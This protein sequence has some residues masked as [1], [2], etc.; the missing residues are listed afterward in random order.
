MEALASRGASQGVIELWGLDER[1]VARMTTSST[2]AVE[3]QLKLVRR[4]DGQQEIFRLDLDPLEATPLE[5]PT[6][7]AD[8]GSL[9]RL[10]SAIELADQ[11]I[12][13]AVHTAAEHGSDEDEAARIARKM[14]EL[15]YL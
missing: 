5:D 7:S 11:H 6:S 10:R 13:A 3:G 8:Q 12:S 4:D 14:R 15:G 2:C 1:A 9:A